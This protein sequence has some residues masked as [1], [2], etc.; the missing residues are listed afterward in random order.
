MLHQE[1]WHDLASHRKQNNA[2]KNLQIMHGLIGSIKQTWQ[3]DIS[4]SALTES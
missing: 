4:V 2:T 1:A 3:H